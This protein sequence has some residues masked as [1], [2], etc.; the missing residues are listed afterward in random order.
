MTNIVL[1][2]LG[3]LFLLYSFIVYIT[4]NKYFLK[5]DVVNVQVGGVIIKAK[6]GQTLLNVL[7]LNQIYIKSACGGGGTCKRC[8][9]KVIEGNIKIKKNEK[10]HFSPAEL[11]SGKRLACQVVVLTEMVVE[12]KN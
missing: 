1:L 7:S 3:L 11:Q 6:R 9:C 5:A 4:F 2:F 10:K 8:V 12:L